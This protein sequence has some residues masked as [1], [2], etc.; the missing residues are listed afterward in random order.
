[1]T[2]TA[3]QRRRRNGGV[4]AGHAPA[5]TDVG[6]QD[7]HVHADLVAR[8]RLRLGCHDHEDDDPRPV[9]GHVGSD[10]MANRQEELRRAAPKVVEDVDGRCSF[11]RRLVLQQPASRR[12]ELD[13]ATDGTALGD[14][15]IS[16]RL[17][18]LAPGLLPELL[19]GR[20]SHGRLSLGAKLC[21]SPGPNVT[22]STAPD[23]DFHESHLALAS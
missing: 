5:S 20:V 8:V 23:N 6:R 10:R 17:V 16:A 13:R 11:S 1:M 19:A 22:G 12:T 7:G 14:A 21:N 4:G 18:S 2:Q 3:R 9:D 15:C